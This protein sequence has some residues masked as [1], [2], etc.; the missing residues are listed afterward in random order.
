MQ[1]GHLQRYQACR[2]GGLPGGHLGGVGGD[3]PHNGGA[4]VGAGGQ[5][6][7]HQG[8]PQQAVVLLPLACHRLCYKIIIIPDAV[9]LSLEHRCS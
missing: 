1:R 9:P 5:V 4:T 2:L 7:A 8:L 6:S 3:G